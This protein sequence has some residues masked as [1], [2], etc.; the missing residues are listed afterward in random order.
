ASGLERL[1]LVDQF[2][3]VRSDLKRVEAELH[4]TS[5]ADPRVTLL[6]TVPGVGPRTAEAFVAYVDRADR[7]SRVNKVGSYFGLVPCQDASAGKERLGHITRQGPSSMRQLLTEAAWMGI[8]KS[9][10]LKAR[11]E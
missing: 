1:L 9:P 2:D 6:M 3:Q 4:K 10:R 11:F 8:R 5:G 7:F